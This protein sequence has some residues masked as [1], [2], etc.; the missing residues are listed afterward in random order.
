MSSPE[1]RHSYKESL[2]PV[3]TMQLGLAALF[4]TPSPKKF[5][6]SGNRFIDDEPF[7]NE[8]K[9]S[10]KMVAKGVSNNQFVDDE[11]FIDKRKPL[12]RTAAKG[13]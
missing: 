13:V 8:R 11:L 7:I 5:D 1:E 6:G 2:P 3:G 4:V 10:S 12:S 9:T